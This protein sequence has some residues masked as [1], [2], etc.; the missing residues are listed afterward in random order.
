MAEP[1]GL[2]PSQLGPPDSIESPLAFCERH[3][4][5]M[6]RKADHNKRESLWSFYLI[7]GLSLLAPLFVTLGQEW[8]CGKL[9]PSVLSLVAAAAMA[10]LQLRKPQ[11]LWSMYRTAQRELEDQRNRFRYRIGAYA[12]H[13]DP[14]KL[15][16]Q[17]VADIAIGVHHQWVPLVPSPEQI[18]HHTVQAEP[19]PNLTAR[20]KND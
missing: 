9:V 13:P 16:A 12:D 15:L 1:N 7:I 8:I 3:I 11:Q 6:S 14:E 20:V 19:H 5:A 2:H 10:W 4:S 18:K 17:N